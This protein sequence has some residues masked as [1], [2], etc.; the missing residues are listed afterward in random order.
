MGAAGA[1]FASAA[2]TAVAESESSSR[3]TA[4]PIRPKL[5]SL[6]SSWLLDGWTTWTG[7]ENTQTEACGLSISGERSRGGRGEAELAELVAGGD[8]G[9]ADWLRAVGGDG[10][11]A[12]LDHVE[13]DVRLVDGPDHAAEF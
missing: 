6:F 3:E 4:E 11:D 12:E 7:S 13:G 2:N 10:V 9:F 1:V 5:I 8:Q